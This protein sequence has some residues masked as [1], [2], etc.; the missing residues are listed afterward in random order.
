MSFFALTQYTHSVDPLKSSAILS[1]LSKRALHLLQNKRCFI[2]GHDVSY[3]KNYFFLNKFYD[4]DID[5]TICQ[6]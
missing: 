2:T 4:A 6:I 5:T 3:L 1:G